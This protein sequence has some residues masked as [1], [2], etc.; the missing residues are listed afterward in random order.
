MVLDRRG[1]EKASSMIAN[2]VEDG[3]RVAYT[4]VGTFW[5]ND[6]HGIIVVEAIDGTNIEVWGYLVDYLCNVQGSFPLV[7]FQTLYPHKNPVHVSAFSTGF[8]LVWEPEYL[9]ASGKAERD[10]YYRTFARDGTPASPPTRVAPLPEGRGRYYPRLASGQWSSG[11]QRP[12][13]YFAI[14]WIL[15]GPE[16]GPR[17]ELRVFKGLFP[18]VPVTDVITVA[19]YTWSGWT[20]GSDGIAA[21]LFTGC[22]SDLRVGLVWQN[23]HLS[24]STSILMRS[25]IGINPGSAGNG[26]GSQATV[27]F[28][29]GLLW[30]NPGEPSLVNPPDLVLEG[31]MT[32]SDEGGE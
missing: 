8:V 1:N 24:D 30:D 29:P 19:D 17:L 4:D 2:W 9:N 12:A 32:E 27:V 3:Q 10:V 22:E 7:S 15:S 21:N 13:P 16:Y 14:T 26:E 25:V 28:S 11:G 18:P 20:V 31:G 5:Y 23:W 6:D